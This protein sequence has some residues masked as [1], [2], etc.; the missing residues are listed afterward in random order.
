MG[1][2]GKRPMGSRVGVVPAWS[3]ICA[4]VIQGCRGPCLGALLCRDEATSD[5]ACST[6]EAATDVAWTEPVG[7]F[8]TVLGVKGGGGRRTSYLTND[9]PSQTKTWVQ[10]YTYPFPKMWVIILKEVGTSHDSLELEFHLCLAG[11]LVNTK[12]TCYAKHAPGAQS[13]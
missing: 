13:S 1:K 11:P 6:L 12:G 4:S 2:N 8:K 9:T 7:G 10:T 3:Q 5:S